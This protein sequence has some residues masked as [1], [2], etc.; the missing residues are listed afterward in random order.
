ME[1]PAHEKAKRPA[2]QELIRGL[3]LPPD[4]LDGLLAGQMLNGKLHHTH[5]LELP[6]NFL[7]AALLQ[8]RRVFG[9]QQ[10]KGRPL[11]RLIVQ[12]PRPAKDNDAAKVQMCIRDRVRI[13]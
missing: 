11:F 12:Y 4:Q 6:L 10:L 3:G 13:G 1:P 2:Y 5:R 7:Q 9:C 8:L